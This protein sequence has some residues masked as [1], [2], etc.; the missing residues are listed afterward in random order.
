MKEK[1]ECPEDL[2]IHNSAVEIANL[3]WSAVG[4]WDHFAKSTLGRQI[5]RSADSIAQNISDGF[6]RFYFKENKLFCYYARGSAYETLC[7]L[8]FAAQRGLISNDLHVKLKDMIEALLPQLNNYINS[9]G[10]IPVETAVQTSSGD[11]KN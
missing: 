1:I 7:S 5:V 4:K 11:H 8:N 9:T 2:R 3:I 10:K 6:G